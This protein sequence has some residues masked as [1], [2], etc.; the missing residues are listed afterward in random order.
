VRPFVVHISALLPEPAVAS[1]RR[2]V[3]I[4]NRR[5]WQEAWANLIINSLFLRQLAE[6]TGRPTADVLQGVAIEVTSLL[7]QISADLPKEEKGD[8]PVSE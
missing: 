4:F 8:G 6:A 1:L 2:Q 7:D 3:A 5:R